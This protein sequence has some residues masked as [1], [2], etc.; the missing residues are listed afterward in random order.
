LLRRVEE[1]EEKAP[2]KR[3]AP[4]K[5]VVVSQP[6]GG[7]VWII[8]FFLFVLF[9]GI[10]FFAGLSIRY[11]KDTD[12][13]LFYD[14]RH[15]SENMRAWKEA[16]ERQALEKAA[17][18]GEPEPAPAP[19]PAPAPTPEPAPVPAP[20]PAPAPAPD[21]VPVPDPA[22]VPVPDPEPAADPAPVPEPAPA[23]LDAPLPNGDP[24]GQ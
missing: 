9:A 12:R 23:P 4:R 16:K 19:A 24:F 15:K 6:E 22:P 3:A 8:G 20:A 18:V 11:Y 21:P 1:P 13:S 7:G 2:V 14:I 17:I 10:A 5:P